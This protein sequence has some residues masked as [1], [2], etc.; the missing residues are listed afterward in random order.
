MLVDTADSS[1]ARQ[2]VRKEAEP[3]SLSLQNDAFEADEDNGDDNRFFCPFPGCTRSFAEL[4]R[5][6]VHFRCVF[7]ALYFNI[8]SRK[9]RQISISCLELRDC[10][11]LYLPFISRA[12]PDVRGSGRERGHGTELAS[13]PRCAAILR[14]GKHHVGCA[15]GKLSSRPTH[16][17]RRK[18]EDGTE[19]SNADTPE[20]S[21]FKQEPTG[22]YKPT[23]FHP[24][25]LEATTNVS[26]IARQ[27][28]CYQLWVLAYEMKNG[29]E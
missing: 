16:S 13:C 4:W 24:S 29:S 2:G 21:A 10:E 23:G 8:C 28:S 3:E 1:Q 12:P 27:G 26:T 15:A 5:L 6:K 9:A 14:P 19:I 25:P 7:C 18:K 22:S 11:P 17:K 20:G